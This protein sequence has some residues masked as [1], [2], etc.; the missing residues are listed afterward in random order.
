[1]RLLPPP[2]TLILTAGL[3]LTGWQIAVQSPVDL[4]GQPGAG[5]TS[6]TAAAGQSQSTRMPLRRTRP[7]RFYA[8]ITDRP[9]FNETRRPSAVGAAAEAPIAAPAPASE[10]AEATAPTPPEVALKG[11]ML[12]G[13]TDSALIAWPDGRT[14]W[15]RLGEKIDGWVLQEIDPGFVTIINAGVTHRVDL[16]R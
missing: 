6:A 4:P 7:D 12:G 16:Y 13:A 5:E 3:G 1:M 9:L 11:L 2:G 8:A 10:P 15:R 14:E